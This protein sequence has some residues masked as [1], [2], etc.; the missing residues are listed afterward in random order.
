MRMELGPGVTLFTEGEKEGGIVDRIQG[1]LQ[2]SGDE[3]MAMSRA[4]EQEAV[5]YMEA[6]RQRLEPFIVDM[7][8]IYGF[9]PTEVYLEL[10]HRIASQGPNVH[11]GQNSVKLLDQVKYNFGEHLKK[12][13]Y[14]EWI[15]QHNVKEFLTAYKVNPIPPETHE[16]PEPSYFVFDK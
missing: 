9:L 8:R 13:S 15:L 2:M 1:L 11:V 10:L 7:L 3:I 4:N 12:D 6:L 5:Y 16:L 14:G